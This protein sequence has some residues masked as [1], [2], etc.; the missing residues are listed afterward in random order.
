VWAN[1]YTPFGELA[2]EFTVFDGARVYAGHFWDE[3]VQLYYAKARWYSP[4]IGRFMSVDPIKDGINWYVYAANNPVAYVDPMGLRASGGQGVGIDFM[5]MDRSLE[6][7][8][9]RDRQRRWKNY[10]ANYI[11]DPI[12]ED[13]EIDV[14]KELEKNPELKEIFERHEIGEFPPKVQEYFVRLYLMTLKPKYEAENGMT[15][16]NAMAD[17]VVK[18]NSKHEQ[19]Y[20]KIKN[21][22][23]SSMFEKVLNYTKENY[24]VTIYYEGAQ[25]Q[26][27]ANKGNVVIVVGTYYYAVEGKIGE[28]RLTTHYSTVAP[29]NIAL[30]SGGI[31]N[32]Y[33][34]SGLKAQLDGMKNPNGQ[35]HFG[36][37]LAQVGAANGMLGQSWA[38]NDHDT[39]GINQG[40]K[41]GDEVGGIVYLQFKPSQ[42]NP[43]AF[44]AE[45]IMSII[46]NSNDI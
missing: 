21:T 35:M 4:E 45:L 26:E 7:A 38:Y 31:W 3:D 15:K 42:T 39:D 41:Y 14:A 33:K 30:T 28:Y 5:Q 13:E 8:A 2:D 25:A 10:L 34:V 29:S 18:G 16:C 20:Q 19:I 24:D 46:Q 32:K 12:S 37:F 44:A 36:P 6:A 9:A 27:E 11:P 1:E 23:G 17:D 40:T 22:E 43:G